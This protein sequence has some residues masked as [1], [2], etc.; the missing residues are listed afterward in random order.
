MPD[1]INK[2][3][4][5]WKKYFGV[6]L[7]AVAWLCWGVIPLFAISNI[8]IAR[9]AVITTI[10]LISSEIL[11]GLG[12][13]FLGKELWTRFQITKKYKIGLKRIKNKLR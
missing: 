10:L 8:G 12:I 5:N 3:M 2:R 9:L 6:L 1:L 13:I 7:I 11:N 4:F